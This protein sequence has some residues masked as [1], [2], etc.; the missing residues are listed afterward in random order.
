M[1]ETKKCAKC[2]STDNP[3]VD[4]IIPKWIYKRS[5]FLGFKKDLGEKN[6]QILCSK[7]NN[8]KSGFIDVTSETGRK[9]WMA[10]R[11][12]INTELEK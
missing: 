11:D 4:H 8:K 10:V 12:L 9:F 5:Q 1:K 6:K 3:T 2:G 7:C